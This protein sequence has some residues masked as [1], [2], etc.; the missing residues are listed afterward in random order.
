MSKGDKAEKPTVS[1]ITPVY[2]AMPY[3]EE[4]LDSVL[5]QTWRPLEFICIDDGSEDT[6]FEYLEALRPTFEKEGISL[7]HRKVK[8]AG[9]AAAVNE[10]LPLAS[11]ELIMWCDAD[12]IMLPEN[13]ERKAVFLMENPQLGMVRNDG[14]HIEYGKGEALDSNRQDR[15]QQNIFDALFHDVTYCYAGCYMLRAS[16]LFSC[17]PEKKIPVSPE[18]QNL[19]LL[20]PPASRS[21]CGYLPDRLHIYRQRPDGHSS[22]KRSFT[23]VLS[24]LKNFTALKMEILQACQCDREYYRQEAFKLEQKC[25]KQ[26]MLS[27]ARKAREERK[28]EGRNSD[29]S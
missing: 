3:F 2:N 24:R 4:Y 25:H 27:A 15:K 14:I 21:E 8:H 6:S 5:R 13:V 18:G 22:R 11:G 12:D 26:L 28:H 29:I 19:Q 20:L 17:Y 10:A 1:L 16:L 7:L 23:E 9:Q